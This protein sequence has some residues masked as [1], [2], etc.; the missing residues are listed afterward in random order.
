MN[1]H[2]RL[3]PSYLLALLLTLSGWAATPTAPLRIVAFGDSTTAPRDTLVV[4]AERLAQDLTAHEIEAEIINAGVPSNTTDDARKRFQ[5][6][7]LDRNPDLV[8]LQFGINDAAVNVWQDPPETQPRVSREQYRD[9]LRYFLRELAARD[10]R[11]ILMTPNPTRWA[12]KT[13]E[14]YGKPP[15]NPD[16]ADGFNVLLR[17]YAE[18]VRDVAAETETPLVDVYAAFQS[19]GA[20]EGQSVDSLLLDGMHPN[21]AGHALVA[22]MLAEAINGLVADKQKPAHP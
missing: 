10:I 13:R 9:N 22:N 17:E 20:V 18:V 8:V 6:D 7:V 4:Y 16:D 19:H 12:P 21:N 15:Y 5:T 14:L 3:R 11:S 1:G 2:H